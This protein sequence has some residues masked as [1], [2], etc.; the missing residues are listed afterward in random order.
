M[1]LQNLERFTWYLLYKRVLLREPESK[2]L[3]LKVLL[4]S[5]ISK[6]SRSQSLLY[7]PLF[8][9]L[10]LLLMAD[11]L[12]SRKVAEMTRRKDKKK[13]QE[14]CKR[15]LSVKLPKAHP[16]IHASRKATVLILILKELS[17]RSISTKIAVVLNGRTMKIGEQA[18][19]IFFL[20]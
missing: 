6:T 7:S 10:Q 13:G 8:L 3:D 2:I 9:H 1:S 16:L 17:K 20:S 4:Q 18:V 14:L 11:V 15:N 12:W 5:K 19:H